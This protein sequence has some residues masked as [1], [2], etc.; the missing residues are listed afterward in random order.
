MK[1]KIISL[2]VN[3][4]GGL[5]SKPLIQDYSYNG[6]PSWG[7]WNNAVISWR[8]K[9]LWE[10]NVDAIVNSVRDFDIIVMQEVD[11]NSDAFKSLIK[12]L[13]EYSIVFPNKTSQKD[14]CRGYKSITVM[15]IKKHIDYE[16][17]TDNFSTKEMK[18]VEVIIDNKIVI[19]LHISMGDICYWDS[20]IKYYKMQKDKKILIIGDM[21][22][23]D[24]GTKQKEKF[25]E[26]LKCGAIDAWVENGNDMNR[27]TA[28]TG[29]RIDYA[30]M[31]PLFYEEL[32][33]ITI[34]DN[35]RNKAITDHSAISMSI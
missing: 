24:C 4:F 3:N 12:R 32:H 33:E 17:V 5:V 6:K 35:L 28:N 1:M 8:E 20:L 2:N 9:I 26:L 27:P 31:S 15:F 19:G 21:N 34:D 23:F 14:F 30:I 11:T 13:D 10:F 29:K 18:N 16:V 25:L 22:V 7:E